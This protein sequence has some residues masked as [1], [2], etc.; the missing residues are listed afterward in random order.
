ML[1]LVSPLGA[2][3]EV[4]LLVAHM[5]QHQLLLDLSPTADQ[6]WAAALMTVEEMLVL[7]TVILVLAWPLLLKLTSAPPPAPE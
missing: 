2:I 3:G 1:A 4:Y 5:G 7:G 6:H